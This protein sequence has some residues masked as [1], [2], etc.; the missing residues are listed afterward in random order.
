M[1]RIFAESITLVFS[2]TLLLGTSACVMESESIESDTVNETDPM[3]EEVAVAEDEQ[4][5]SNCYEYP[6]GMGDSDQVYCGPLPPP[7]PPPPPPAFLGW[8]FSA[9]TASVVRR[10]EATDAAFCRA[11]RV[12]LVGSMMPSSIMSP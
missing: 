4:G 3:A 12:T 7:P 6:D 5:L 2:M 11:E 8:G 1:T 9:M 10:S